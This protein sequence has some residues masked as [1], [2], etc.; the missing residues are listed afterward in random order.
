MS[1]GYFLE[2]TGAANETYPS[3]GRG[4]SERPMANGKCSNCGGALEPGFIATT[5]GSGLF[6]AREPADRRLR[7]T[8]LEVLVPTGYQGTYSANLAGDRCPHC[9]TI[10]VRLK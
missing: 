4:R 9:A 3:L 5:N 10:L 6:W 8:G 1:P 2:A 7:P